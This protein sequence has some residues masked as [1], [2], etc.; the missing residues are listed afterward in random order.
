[1]ENQETKWESWGETPQSPQTPT[2]ITTPSHIKE[3]EIPPLTNNNKEPLIFTSF[4]P[5]TPPTE[6][7]NWEYQ[8]DNNQSPPPSDSANWEWESP[9]TIE[10]PVY[11][12]IETPLSSNEKLVDL[13]PSSLGLITNFKIETDLYKLGFDSNLLNKEISNLSLSPLNNT[14]FKYD[15]NPQPNT[16]LG[17]VIHSIVNVGKIHNLKISNCFVGKIGGNNEL[18]HIFEANSK[19]NFIYFIKSSSL[20]GD[21]YIDL[22]SINGPKPKLTSLTTD[23]LSIIPGWVPCNILSK[24]GEEVIFIAGGFV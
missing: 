3:W 20:D 12:E 6:E 15:F 13:S 11:N 24:G 18:K 23:V 19:F 1:M 10:E 2:E 8:I 9:S 4:T 5:E 16:E 21:L 7:P 22:T 14:Q 17:N